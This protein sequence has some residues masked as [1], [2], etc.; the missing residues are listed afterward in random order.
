MAENMNLPI[1]LE[2]YYSQLHQLW[3]NLQDNGL[4]DNGSIVTR[5]DGSRMPVSK[6][7]EIL[8]LFPDMPA[9]TIINDTNHESGWYGTMGHMAQ[10]LNE[11][12]TYQFLIS[13]GLDTSILDYYEE[14]SEWEFAGPM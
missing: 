10:A 1:V 3:S 12:E 14:N 6:I 4:E 8:A 11:P 9:A 5:G 13:M 2:E 7:K